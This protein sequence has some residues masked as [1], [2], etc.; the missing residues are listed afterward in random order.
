MNWFSNH[1]GKNL[2]GNSC[3]YGRRLGIEHYKTCLLWRSPV[4]GWHDLG[5]CSWD[6]V[7]SSWFGTW[8][9]LTAVSAYALTISA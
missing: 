7:F 1:F 8:L 5:S 2:A 6:F 3:P 9:F 4:S